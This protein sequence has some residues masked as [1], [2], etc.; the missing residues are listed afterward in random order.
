MICQ[1]TI[2]FPI[3]Q[4]GHKGCSIEGAYTISS[5]DLSRIL[6]R[7]C[8]ICYLKIKLGTFREVWFRNPHFTIRQLSTPVQSA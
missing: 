7:S 6:P 4:P 5:A 8:I 3:E 1:N 2:F